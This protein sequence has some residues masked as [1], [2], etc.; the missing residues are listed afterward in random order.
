MNRWV[1]NEAYKY[2]LKSY[3]RLGYDMTWCDVTWCEFVTHR[4]TVRNGS[5][6]TAVQE[7]DENKKYKKS[8]G[9]DCDLSITPHALVVYSYY[10]DVWQFA[11]CALWYPQPRLKF[12]SPCVISIR[13]SQL[14]QLSALA[15]NNPCACASAPVALK[16]SFVHSRAH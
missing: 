16:F 7:S 2:K 6:P 5:Q 3:N 1:L 13:H 12:L 15:L 14:F 11:I 8:T 9:N 4:K 10:F